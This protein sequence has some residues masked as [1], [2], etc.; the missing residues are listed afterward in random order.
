MGRAWFPVTPF[1]KPLSVSFGP[2][3]MADG[4]GATVV[5][6]LGDVLKRHG[7]ER[8]TP[9]EI[10]LAPEDVLSGDGSIPLSVSFG[11]Q[12]INYRSM[13]FFGRAVPAGEIDVITFRLAG[14]W[15]WQHDEPDPTPYTGAPL[16][17]DATGLPMRGLGGSGG[18]SKDVTGDI[19]EGQ[20]TVMSWLEPSMDVSRVTIVLSRTKRL[21]N[22]DWHVELKPAP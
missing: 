18:F 8:G 9:G 6:A 17:L 19:H 3:S 22:G 13:A 7:A 12:Q 5:V 4:S 2:Y 16:L 10:P 20:T 21:V 1:G 15:E 11:K 14:T